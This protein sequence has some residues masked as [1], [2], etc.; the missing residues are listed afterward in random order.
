MQ[1]SP[2]VINASNRL[3]NFFEGYTNGHANGFGFGFLTGYILDEIFLPQSQQ[4]GQS[5]TQ[6]PVTSEGL[7][8]PG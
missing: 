4:P 7:F 3:R 2:R 1:A 5:Q 8:G 6:P